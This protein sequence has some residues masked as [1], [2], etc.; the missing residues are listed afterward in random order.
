VIKLTSRRDSVKR[1]T[2][3]GKLTVIG[4]PFRTYMS[5]GRSPQKVT[6]CVCRCECGTVKVI[7]AQSLT[8]GATTS[9]G[10]YQIASARE[11]NITHGG[12]LKSQALYKRWFGMVARCTNPMSPAWKDY[13]GRGITVC[14]EWLA[15]PVRFIE[16]SLENGFSEELEIDRRDNNRGYSPDNCRWVTA[17]VNMN[18]TRNTTKVTAFGETKSIS[19]WTRDERCRIT[20]ASLTYRLQQGMTPED[21]ISLA[22]HGFKRKSRKPEP[23]GDLC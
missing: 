19:E 2:G 22:P 4:E 5:G 15:S 20:K 21:A 16:W 1:G 12:Y 7:M 9:C 8:K 14:D 3:F 11:N 10:C 23:V 18:N 17:L 13:G 6:F